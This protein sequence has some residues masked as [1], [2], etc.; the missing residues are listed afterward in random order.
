[1]TSRPETG[2]SPITDVIADIKAG[3]MAVLVDEGFGEGIEQ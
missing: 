1:M 3:R 2:I